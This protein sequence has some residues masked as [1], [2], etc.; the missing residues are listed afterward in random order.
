[1][2]AA[3][4]ISEPVARLIRAANLVA[5]GNLAA[6]VPTDSDIGEINELSQSFNQMTDDLNQQT[7]ALVAARG[8]A[9]NRRHFI[10]TVRSGVSAGVVGLDAEGR[11]SAYNEQ[12]L[13]LLSVKD[14][15][16][17][18][19]ALAEVAPEL[20]EIA[21]RAL[22]TAAGAEADINVLRGSETRRL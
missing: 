19:R 10:E 3:V 15:T 2:S 1:M 9:D 13:R 5:S 6:R 4:S 14:D 7:S 18:G 20:Q 16:L 21:D 17:R 22:E 12:A 11:I 8:D